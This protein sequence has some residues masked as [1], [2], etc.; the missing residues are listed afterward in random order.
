MTPW[1]CPLTWGPGRG[2]IGQLHREILS[3]LFP[4]SS[5]PRKLRNANPTQLFFAL[6]P[7]ASEEPAGPAPAELALF[8]K[9]SK[10]GHRSCQ[11][12]N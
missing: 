12:V 8:G 1:T 10:M 5:I 6:E 2:C 4:S 11:D 7:E 3:P 9:E